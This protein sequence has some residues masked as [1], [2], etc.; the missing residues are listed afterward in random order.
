V[1]AILLDIEGTTTPVEFVYDVL[2]PYV[3]DHVGEF[4]RQHYGSAEVRVDLEQL[5]KDYAAGAAEK[6]NPALWR[7]DSPDA[8]LESAVTYVHWLMGRDS[9]STALKSLQGKICEAGYRSGK[10][11]GAVYEDVPRVLA[12]WYEQAKEIAIFSS[13]SVLAQRLLFATT[14]AGDLT[15]FISA[16]FD[17]ATGP[18]RE[19]GS[20]RRISA[21]LR[22]L[23]SEVLFLSDVTTELDAAQVAGMQTALCVRPGRPEPPSSAHPVIHTFDEITFR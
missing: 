20:Y 15:R 4:L 23:P 14:P 9:K 17:T 8:R 3:R 7:D 21:A 5:G 18:K 1:R 6:P 19:A 2:F 13:G 22:M 11:R 12:R 10:L 16:Y